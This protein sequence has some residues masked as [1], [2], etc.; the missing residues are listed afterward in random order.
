MI[1]RVL[2]FSSSGIFVS[3]FFVR[4][5]YTLFLPLILF[6]RPDERVGCGD[7]PAVAIEL[8]VEPLAHS[9]QVLK[10]VSLELCDEGVCTRLNEHLDRV[11]RTVATLYA[12][13]L[14]GE[15]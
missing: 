6:L 4:F 1:Q 14:V 3:L 2:F 13:D 5:S 12:V 8:L 15:E 9:R 7:D 10:P 11:A